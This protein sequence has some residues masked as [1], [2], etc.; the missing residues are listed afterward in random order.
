MES[1]QLGISVT[2]TALPLPNNTEE[3]WRLPHLCVFTLR[4]MERQSE[5]THIQ[6]HTHTHTLILY[7]N[8]LPCQQ[9]WYKDPLLVSQGHHPKLLLALLFYLLVSLPLSLSVYPPDIYPSVTF[10]FSLS[11]HT[12]RLLTPTCGR[13]ISALTQPKRWSLGWKSW[14]M[15]PSSTLNQSEGRCSPRWYTHRSYIWTR[16]PSVMR[17]GNISLKE[18]LP[19]EE[20]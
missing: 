6:L 11:T 15:L 3:V 10:N 2:Y 18:A 19:L 4:H 12:A 5:S 9:E 7:T 1:W 20:H 8:T 14:R 17:F 13:I 16:L